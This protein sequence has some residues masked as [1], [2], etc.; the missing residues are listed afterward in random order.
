MVKCNKIL[1]INELSRSKNLS[2]KTLGANNSEHDCKHSCIKMERGMLPLLRDLRKSDQQLI[3]KI[4]KLFFQK[5]GKPLYWK[6][7]GK[8]KLSKFSRTFTY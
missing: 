8:K 5:T 1:P 2:D 4:V 6:D 7:H 3:W